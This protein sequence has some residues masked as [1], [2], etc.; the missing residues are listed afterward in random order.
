MSKPHT[1]LRSQGRSLAS[2]SPCSPW[3]AASAAGLMISEPKSG[4]FGWSYGSTNH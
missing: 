1:R 2:S 3:G 4:C